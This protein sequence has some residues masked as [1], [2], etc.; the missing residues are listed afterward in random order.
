MYFRSIYAFLLV[1]AMSCTASAQGAIQAQIAKAEA[2]D[3]QAQLGVAQAYQYGL[4][5]EKNV[6][7]AIH[8]YEQAA[9]QSSPLAMYELGS[10]VYAGVAP[11]DESQAAKDAA[12]ASLAWFE[13]AA[14]LGFPQAQST[15]GLMYGFGDRVERNRA[16]GRMW[17]ATA[18]LN[19]YKPS[20]TM[21]KMLEKQM[22]DADIATAQERAVACI[23]SDYTACE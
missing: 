21:V 10:L 1:L 23:A 11:E 9:A 3:M 13:K 8:W 22:D 2:G 17:I 12:A 15:L 19:G 6:E 20:G 18:E 16:I 4:G 14:K 7:E 5:T